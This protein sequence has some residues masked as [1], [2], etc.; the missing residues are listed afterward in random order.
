MNVRRLLSLTGLALVAALVA[1][2]GQDGG[3]YTV[4]VL[5]PSEGPLQSVGRYHDE[6]VRKAFGLQGGDLVT[7]LRGHSLHI[8]FFGT[9]N[10]VVDRSGCAEAGERAKQAGAIAIVGPVASGCARHLLSQGLGIPIISSLSTAPNLG[11]D[12]EWFFRTIAHDRARLQTFVDSARRW[13]VGVDRSVAIY[14]SSTYGRGLYSHLEDLVSLGHGH[15]YRW[16]QVFEERAHGKLVPVDDFRR[17]VRHYDHVHENVFVLGSSGRMDTAVHQLD[18]L[19]EETGSDPNFV[20]VGS[21]RFMQ[22]FPQDTT[23]VIGEAKV[24]TSRNLVTAVTEHTPSGN[25]YISTFDAGL[26]VEHALADVLPA[27]GSG[28][29]SAAEVRRELRT[30]LEQDN[31]PS[32]ERGRHIEFEDGETEY[33]PPTPIYRVANERLVENT[34]ASPRESWV[35]VRVAEEPG[36]QLAGP[37]VV[38]LVPH[39]QDLVGRRVELQA[40]GIGDR[41]VEVEEVELEENGTTVSFVPARLGGHWFPRTF[42]LTTSESPAEGARIDGMGWPV[43]YLLAVLA[44]LTGALLYKYRRRRDQQVDDGA[45]T[46]SWSL[47]WFVRRCV[48]GVAIAFL[49]VHLGPI[50]ETLQPPL[51]KIPVPEFGPSTWVNSF[52]SG[53]LG[54]WLGLDPILALLGAVVGSVVPLFQ[55]DG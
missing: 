55:A 25:H 3:E 42:R 16:D 24:N 38:E 41:P 32:S 23:W 9:G 50:I 34:N 28:H 30:E 5:S 27:G 1:A 8:R 7:G 10:P 35:E 19:F 39:G 46:V 18:A 11:D 6:S 37:V 33:P 49:V 53:L 4:A 20:I 40:R 47:W 48:A 2:C 15:S 54:G 36:G 21:T 52:I 13:N 29:P 22:S 26:A 12:S 17:E 51:S 31:F 14:R 43:T 44:A 45:G